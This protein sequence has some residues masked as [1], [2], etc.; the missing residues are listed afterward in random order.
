[1]AHNMLTYCDA[2][3]LLNRASG[4]YLLDSYSCKRMFAMREM[5]WKVALI[6]EIARPWTGFSSNAPPPAEGMKNNT[7]INSEN[8]SF[9]SVKL[10]QVSLWPGARL[11]MGWASMI[12]VHTETLSG[13]NNEGFLWH[14]NKRVL[15]SIDLT[16][17]WPPA[18]VQM[19]HISHRQSYIVVSPPA[20]M[21]SVKLN[22]DF[23]DIR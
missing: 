19:R 14:W 12:T 8:I 10:L 22:C 13:E 5:K 17:R 4:F 20:A 16:N 15:S 18:T 7:L 23:H 3:N 2:F 1:M 11:G 21:R 6:Q 9:I